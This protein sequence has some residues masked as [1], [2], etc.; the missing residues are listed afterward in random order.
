MSLT[1][2]LALSINYS[3]YGM[4]FVVFSPSLLILLTSFV[5]GTEKILY[6]PVFYPRQLN[7]RQNLL[8]VLL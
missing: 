2:N 8:L 3:L 1:I 4:I 5:I 6:F 7:F